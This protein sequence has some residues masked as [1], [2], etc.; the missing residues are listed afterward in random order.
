MASILS[1][2]TISYKI[3]SDN[4]KEQTYGKLEEISEK[5]AA[6]IEGWLSIQARVLNELYDE[7]IYRDDFDRGN[8]VRY[9]N[10]KNQKN[11]DVIE[12]YIAL[13]E[14]LFIRGYGLWNPRGDYNVVERDWYINAIETDGMAVSSPYVDA[15][16]GEVIVTFSKAIRIND[17]VIGVLASDIA[18]DH[19]VNIIHESNPLENG[20]S[21][22]IGNDG[23]ILAHPNKEFLYSREKGLT[24]IDD[25]YKGDASVR[26]LGKNK[27][28]SIMDYDGEERFVLYTDLGFT[29][30]DIG[31]AAPIKEVMQP[32][33][34]M[35]NNSINLTLALT[36]ISILLTFI[37]GNSISKPIKVATD[38]IEKMAKLD[39]TQ[40]I[41]EEYIGLKDEIGRMF[42]A[43]QKIVYSLREFLGELT[44]ISEKISTFSDELAALSYQSSIDTDNMAQNSANVAELNDGY[45]KNMSKILL[46]MENLQIQAKKLINENKEVNNEPI[47]N[48]ARL[49]IQDL[50][51][52]T[53]ELEKM[54]DIGS[55]EST[56]FKN[57]Y[58]LIEKQTL[59]ME[60]ISSASQC[61]AEL[62]DELNIYISKFKS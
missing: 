28:N 9:F 40:D 6:E 12:F 33:N 21:F 30:W 58:A 31:L 23:N 51:E 49:V 54:Q 57:I 50:E 34:K 61:L 5:H 55:F 29:G 18:I 11:P 41:D 32:V 35:I 46:S 2:T 56:Q 53:R 4:I 59:I 42:N 52:L 45:M 27:L 13:P 60:E 44:V 1:A 38:Y 8:L 37:L 7:I 39:I 16:H 14:N 22:L 19:I 24:N 20:Y 48:S 47:I 17:E 3:L 15:N 43:F 62:G 10:Y 26:Y 36:F 25:I